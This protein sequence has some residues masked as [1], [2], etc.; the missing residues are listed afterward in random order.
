MVMNDDAANDP[1]SFAEKAKSVGVLATENE[2]AR[3]LRELLT[4]GLKGITAYAD[5]AAVPGFRKTEINDFLRKAL[6]ATIQTLSGGGGEIR[7]HQ[8]LC[9]HGR[10]RRS[11]GSRILFYGAGEPARGHCDSD[12][13]VCKIALQQTGLR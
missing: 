7:R 10:L 5:H 13:R 9:G 4:I 1:A 8:T 12:C 6:A 11:P 2:E 3:S